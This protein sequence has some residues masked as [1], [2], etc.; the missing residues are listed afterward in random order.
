MGWT[1][2]A[3]TLKPPVITALTY[4]RRIPHAPLNHTLPLLV[5]LVID[6]L[7]QAMCVFHCLF[8]LFFHLALG[9][10]LAASPP[11]PSSPST[12]VSALDTTS[13]SL[14]VPRPC[15]RC[16][17]TARSTSVLFSAT[18][19]RNIKWMRSKSLQV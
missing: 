10:G 12:L 13:F 8:P 19:A 11:P 5:A 1:A 2:Q 17:I 3:C 7:A 14:M 18:S 16:A 4:T 9:G 15:V 6:L